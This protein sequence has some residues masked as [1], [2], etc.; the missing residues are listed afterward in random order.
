MPLER[1]VLGYI[2]INNNNTS[3]AADDANTSIPIAPTYDTNAYNG[4][5][6]NRN[7]LDLTGNTQMIEYNHIGQNTLKNY[8]FTLTDIMFCMVDNIPGKLFDCESLK[9]TNT[10]DTGLLSETNRKQRNFLK[11]R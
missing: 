4:I 1:T 5:G 11:A 2:K 8:F 10:R 6:G 3:N 9:S 7:V